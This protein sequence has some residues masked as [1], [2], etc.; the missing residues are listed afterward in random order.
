[1]KTKLT[2]I[3]KV[4][5]IVSSCFIP[6]TIGFGYMKQ[7]KPKQEYVSSIKEN[8]TI[9]VDEVALINR[10]FHIKKNG[11]VDKTVENY[12]QCNKKQAK[13]I[14]IDFDNVNPMKVGTY[15]VT[16]KY[17]DKEFTFTIIVDESDNP[18][19]KADKTEFKYIINEYSDI[20][21]IKQIIGATAIDHNGKD[22]TN[23]ITGFP[24]QFP[25]E[26]GH[27]IYYLNVSDIYGN[28]GFLEIDINFELR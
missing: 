27:Q 10:E 13:E 2:K 22:L 15:K 28:T 12:F 6:L 3:E 9:K 5:L 1:M 14:K 7:A 16:G 11:K 21:E 25:E 4:V 18:T 19:I 23:D 8:E 20:K 26:K 24:T 17:K